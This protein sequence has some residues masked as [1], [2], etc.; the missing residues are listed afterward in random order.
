MPTSNYSNSIDTQAISQSLAN[1]MPNYNA[2]Y[3]NQNTPL[4]GASTPGMENFM[5]NSEP[6]AANGVL[7]GGGSF[8]SW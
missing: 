1:N 8:G 6:M 2:M 3:Q 7:G 5:G 4:Q